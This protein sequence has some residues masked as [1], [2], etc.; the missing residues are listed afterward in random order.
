MG[1]LPD[2]QNGLQDHGP[3]PCRDT[4]DEGGILSKVRGDL[5]SASLLKIAIW[6]LIFQPEIVKGGVEVG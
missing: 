6:L 3:T 1:G 5:T 4:S 2:C